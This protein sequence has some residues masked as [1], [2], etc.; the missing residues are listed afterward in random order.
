MTFLLL[1]SYL[2]KIAV[3]KIEAHTKKTE[4]EHQGN[5]LAGFHS[6]AAATE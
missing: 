1:F 6:K 3:I 4:P 2:L 5:A